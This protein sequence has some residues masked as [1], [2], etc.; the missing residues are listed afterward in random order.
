VHVEH[1]TYGWITPGLAY[2]VSVL[3]TWLGLLCTARARASGERARRGRWLVLAAWSIGGT[4]IWVMQYMAM[5]GFSMPGFQVRYNIPTTVASWVTAVAVVGIGLF[6]VGSGRPGLV[7]IVAAGIFMGVGLAV[8]HYIGVRA[9]RV[10]ATVSYDPGLVEVSVAIAVLGS[11]LA[12]W[13]TATLRRGPAIAGAALVIAAVFIAM[14]YTAMYAMR[15]S[16]P[17]P[18]TIDGLLPIT[19]IGPIAVLVVAVIAVLLMALLSR[20]GTDVRPALAGVSD[21][22]AH[23]AA[24]PVAGANGT[25]GPLPTRHPQPA[26]PAAAPQPQPPRRPERTSPAAFFT[27]APR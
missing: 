3:G 19:F 5:I 20:A 17:H 27:R 25:S 14:H 9:L 1:F 13:F 8:M 18:R 26:A 24:S 11:T 22:P 23:A 12:L 10:P 21:G 2:A 4:G 7:K 15:F 16:G 6:I